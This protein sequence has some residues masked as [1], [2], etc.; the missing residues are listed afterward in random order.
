MINVNKLKAFEYDVIGA[1][2]AVHRELGAGLHEACYQEGLQIE[3]SERGI[4]F[5]REMSFHPTYR[6][7]MMESVFR[8][9]FLCKDEII[10]QSLIFR[11]SL[12]TPPPGSLC[13]WR[14]SAS[15][16]R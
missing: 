12:R 11:S 4:P 9:D 3:L 2:Y 1:I 14:I 8:L 15:D 7:K 6:G 13:L 5:V 10:I 16:R